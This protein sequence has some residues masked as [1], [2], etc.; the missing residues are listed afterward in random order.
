MIGA[1]YFSSLPKV[2]HLPDKI[3]FSTQAW[4]AYVPPET[5]YVG[6]VN[7]E[8][9][10]DASGN[11]T[12]FG[13]APLLKL[14]QLPFDLYAHD[15][16]YEVDIELPT[17]E[18]NGTVTLLMVSIDQLNALTARLSNS[19]RIPSQNYHGFE[20]YSVLIGK[21]GY[22]ESKLGHLAI[23]NGYVLFSDDRLAGRRNVER[24][25]EQA[26]RN[27]PNL[28]DDDAVRR[29]IYAS[30]VG[31]QPYIGLYVGMFASQLSNTKMIVKSVIRQG[32]GIS[33]TR[34]ILFSNTDAALGQFGEAHRIYHDASSYRV[35]DS[36]LVITF[37][38]GMSKLR[39]ELIGI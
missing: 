4:M 13:T 2:E 21:P 23:F 26:P 37:Q 20:V 34:A 11:S 5:Y 14:A 19:T 24:V 39:G 17:P 35:L 16:V 29:S 9:A 6:Y 12:L 22:Q 25:I 36:W 38:Y 3:Q 8:D 27:T 1:S 32:N 18:Y 28:F 15:I 7:Y 31:D 33:V 30:G 10:I